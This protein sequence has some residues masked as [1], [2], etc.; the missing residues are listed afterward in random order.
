VKK[1]LKQDGG[2]ENVIFNI[3]ITVFLLLLAI[4]TLYPMLNTLAVSFND[5]TDTIRGGIYL[6]PRI[7][8]LNNYKTIWS[9]QSLGNAFVVSVARTV[10]G[11]GL[12]VLLTSMVAYTLTR[13]EFVLN[14]FVTVLY[15]LT[16][17]INAGL[18]PGYMVRKNFGLL[19]KFIVYVIPGVVS[20]FNLIVVR[21]YMKTIPDSLHESAEVDGAGEFRIYWNIILPL[22]LPVLATVTLFSAVGQWN[23][24][25]DTMLYCSSKQELHTLQYKLMAALQSSMN[26][27]GASTANVVNTEAASNQVTP[28]S[29]RA[30]TT[31]VAAVPIL[32]VYPFMQKYFVTGMTVGSVKG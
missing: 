11:A 18:I 24:W 20:A 2:V 8:T 15:V 5:A 29:I 26:Q 25:F 3:V 21:T 1:K 13:Q 22:A 9:T 19:N 28:V 27:S 16:M 23:S 17:Y 7:W 30:A 12:D 4:V 6:W 14:K 32:V 31:I 10:I